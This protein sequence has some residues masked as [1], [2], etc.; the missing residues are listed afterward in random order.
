MIDMGER[1]SGPLPGPTILLF[2][3]LA[4]S[5]DEAAFTQL[6]KTVAEN[7]EFRWVLDTVSEFPQIWKSLTT[8]IPSLQS[9]SGLKQLEDLADAFRSGRQLE[10]PFPLPNKLLI[11][12][13]IV[14]HLTQ[15]ATFVRNSTEGFGAA[16]LDKETL[17][18]CT[19]LLSAFAV[20]STGSS[21]QFKKY[22]AVAVRLAMLIGTV[23]DAQDE[24][25]EPSKSLS[26]AWNS[27][28]SGEELQRII[29]TFPEVRH[30]PIFS[31]TPFAEP[32]TLPQPT[33]PPLSYQ[34]LI[35]NCRLT[36]R[37]TTTRTEPP[38][39]PRL[40]PSPSCNNSSV[41]PV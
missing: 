11:P 36:F 38:S 30:K 21:E 3:P 32:G 7:E 29:K 16:K 19:G 1:L 14:S 26:A 4:L 37:S 33:R 23:V 20:A 10:T 8:S 35:L 12:L 17:G 22:G 18:L 13:V 5:F 24:A 9:T 15:Y 6:R 31:Q 39:P 27:A 34:T 40:P 28:Q 25:T 41:V 2:G